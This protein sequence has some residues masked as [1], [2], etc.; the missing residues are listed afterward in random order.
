VNWLLLVLA[1]VGT[2]MAACGIA[3]EVRKWRCRREKRPAADPDF[4]AAVV[5]FRDAC[6]RGRVWFDRPWDEAQLHAK[7]CVLNHFLEGRP[8]PDGT[9]CGTCSWRGTGEMCVRGH[10]RKPEDPAC[11]GHWGYAD[12]ARNVRGELKFPD[13]ET[14]V[15]DTLGKVKR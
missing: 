9:T 2:V 5:R 1:A 13:I 7:L 4:V 8:V 15:S 6:A 3:V 12:S 10:G 11:A 14:G